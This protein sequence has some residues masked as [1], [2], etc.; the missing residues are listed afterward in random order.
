MLT[1][2]QEGSLDV[3]WAGTQIQYE[4]QLTPIRIP[5]L[6]GMLGHRIFI[7]RQGDQHKFN[8]VH[9]LQDLMQIPLGQ[10]RFWGDTLVLRNA[11]LNVVAPV[12]YESL[13]YMLDGGRFDFFP[14]ALHE[15]WSE[16]N[17]RPEL[18]LEVENRILLI[19]PF[20][21]YFFVAQDRQALAADIQNGFRR[22]IDDGS[23]DK[24]FFQHQ[25]VK[26]ALKQSNLK[27]RLVL[28]LE[29]PNMSPETPIHDKSLW[30]NIDE[31]S[32]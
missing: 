13:F 6:K 31:L 26:D 1:M 5:V 8:Q 24:L 30:L 28:R 2:L 3:M 29:N 7:I 20:A 11:N 4:Q 27:Q 12:K 18:D 17:S 21:M 10:G 9:S 15:P 23:Y 32:F 16:I 22:A 19:Y 25:M 14:R